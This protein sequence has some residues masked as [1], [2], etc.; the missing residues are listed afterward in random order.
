MSR[1]FLLLSLPLVLT[2]C[3]SCGQS[4]PSNRPDPDPE[5]CGTACANLQR[6]GCP[7]GNDIFIP[8]QTPDAGPDAGTSVTCTAWCEETQRNGHAL[9][10]TCVSGIAACA[11]LVNCDW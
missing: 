7:E 3:A 1:L 4:G 9:N 5:S 2:S 10:A 6:L 11:D 8:D